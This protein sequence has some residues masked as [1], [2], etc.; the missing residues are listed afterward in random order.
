MPEKPPARIRVRRHPER[1]HYDAETVNEI[2]DA[3]LICHVGFLRQQEPVV[4]PTLHVRVGQSLYLHGAVASG[5]LRL[6]AAGMPVCVTA[7]EL[8]GIVLARSVYNH[9]LNYR[10]V[11]VLGQAVEVTDSAKKLLVLEALV[12]KVQ[13]GRWADARQPNPT[14]LRATRL[15]EVP[16]EA[17]SAKVRV[18]PPVDDE[19]DMGLPVWA[20]V[21]PLTATRGT[22]QP[23][24]ALAAGIALP[25]YLT[26]ATP[27]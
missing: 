21:V 15:I 4:L 26:G 8:D 10:S 13:P 24:P 17:A 18:G 20:G 9:S 1:G 6:A 3:A 14:E 7:T 27:G 16:I 25:A 11:V 2:L 12:E 5:M 23:D 22:P 19:E